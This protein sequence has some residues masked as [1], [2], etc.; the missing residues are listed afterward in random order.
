MPPV[1][2]RARIT[3]DG[4]RRSECVTSA[5]CPWQIEGRLTVQSWRQ[6][7]PSSR[8]ITN[9]NKIAS[10]HPQ[11]GDVPSLDGLERVA[12]LPDASR[13]G[14]WNNL[15][16]HAQSHD[17]LDDHER[18]RR[19]TATRSSSGPGKFCV[20]TPVSQCPGAGGGVTIADFGPIH[21]VPPCLVVVG[22][23]VLV[24]RVVGLLPY[25]TSLPNR[26]GSPSISRLS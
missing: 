9:L 23:P 11:I 22:T 4:A 3:Q 7:G 20:R 24:L 2:T 18:G 13:T 10:E 12:S 8:Q 25:Q 26:T 5:S 17:V 1:W 16:G 21:H 14:V 19:H 6:Y 15:G